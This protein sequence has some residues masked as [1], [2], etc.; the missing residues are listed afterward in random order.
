MS[1]SPLEPTPQPRTVP[2]SL[3]SSRVVAEMTPT[4]YHAFLRTAN[5]KYEYIDG[6]VIQMSGASPEHNRITK[7]FIVALDVSIEQAQS[8]C[9]VFGSDQKIYI[10]PSRFYLPDAVVV[11]GNEQF[12]F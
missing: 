8:D 4:E 10:S 11:C 6:K 9:D 2:V 12:D 1:A 3:N 5:D 7:N